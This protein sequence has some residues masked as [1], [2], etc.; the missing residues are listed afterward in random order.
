MHYDYSKLGNTK[1]LGAVNGDYNI[2]KGLRFS[3]RLGLDYFSLEEPSYFNPYFGDFVTEGGKFTNYYTRVFNWVWTNTLDYQRDID[4]QGNLSADLK[5]GYEA[6][7]SNEYDISADGNGVPQLTTL[8]L[9]PTSN[10]DLAN[11]SGSDYSFSSLFSNLQLNFRN[12][13]IVSGSLRS[14]GSSR[15]GSNNRYG[16]FWSVGAAWNIDK[17]DFLANWSFISAL[18]LRASYGTNGNANIGN[19][20]SRALYG[21]GADYN[22]IPGSG[23]SSVGNTNLTWEQNKPFDVGLELGI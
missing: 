5:V 8:P 22:K 19:Y 6:Q 2:I 20:S 16:T 11:A 18:K 21:F 17:E 3:T 10:P 12:K 4:K 1:L 9:P 7:R 13:I 15:F 23:P 14:D